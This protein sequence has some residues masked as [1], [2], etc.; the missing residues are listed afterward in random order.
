MPR[1]GASPAVMA[2]NRA[3]RGGAPLCL[4]RERGARTLLDE[5]SPS[6]RYGRRTRS[7]NPA[8]DQQLL[9]GCMIVDQSLRDATI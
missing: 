7:R 2:S 5:P 4:S 3:S 9:A 6:Q 8:H 1:V